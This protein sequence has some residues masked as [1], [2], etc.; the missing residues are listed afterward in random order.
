M[1]S[2]M[3]Q[4]TY[5]NHALT[6]NRWYGS[7]IFDMVFLDCNSEICLKENFLF[8]SYIDSFLSTLLMLFF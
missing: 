5:S 8:L 2:L 4:K 7:Q 3:S 6:S 1:Y